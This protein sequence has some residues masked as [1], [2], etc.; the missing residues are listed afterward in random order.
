MYKAISYLLDDGDILLSKTVQLFSRLWLIKIL[1]FVLGPGL[2]QIERKN[3]QKTQ[4]HIKFSMYQLTFAHNISVCENMSLRMNY[5][6]FYFICLCCM[7][8]LWSHTLWCEIWCFCKP[9]INLPL[10][11]CICFSPSYAPSDNKIREGRNV[12]Y[13]NLFAHLPL[14]GASAAK[15]VLLGIIK[16]CNYSFIFM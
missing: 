1:M 10:K 16:S 14:L 6:A 12:E 15:S 5:V 8:S 2:N 9:S 3:P 7:W 4:Y 11:W 13:V